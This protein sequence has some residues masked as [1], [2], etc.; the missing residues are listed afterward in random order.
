MA[1]KKPNIL[2]ET[3]GAIFN[4]KEYIYSLTAEQVKQM[5]FM[6]NRRL[7]IK[8]PLQAQVFNTS[9]INPVDVLHFWVD[10]LHNG[11]YPPRWIYTA[12]AT[13]SQVKK[14]SKK[15]ISRPLI[16]EYCKHH[17]ISLKD[18]DSAM[19]FFEDTCIKEVKEFEQYL[20]LLKNEE[21]NY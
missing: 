21:H 11:M 15:E 9:K 18:F 17:K 8:Y 16:K 2:F 4:N 1:E 13:K 19:K 10:Y 3:L 5:Y 12:G 7:A 14:E 6:I 20:K